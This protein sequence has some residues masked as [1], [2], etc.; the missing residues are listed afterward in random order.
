M[1]KVEL[2]A[3][4]RNFAKKVIK[5][6]L[7]DVEPNDYYT[8]LISRFILLKEKLIKKDINNKTLYFDVTE[9]IEYVP[10][11]RFIA[12]YVKRK[13]TKYIENDLSIKIQNKFGSNIGEEEIWIINKLRDSFVHGKYDID[14]YMNIININN[15]HSDDL[16]NAYALECKVPIEVLEVLQY[17]AENP[18]EEYDDSDIEEFIAYTNKVR[19]DFN[20]FIK[21]DKSLAIF[22]FDRLKPISSYFKTMY[23]QETDDNKEEKYISDSGLYI[24][25]EIKKQEKNLMELLYIAYNPLLTNEEELYKIDK[26]L[27]ENGIVLEQISYFYYIV[28]KKDPNMNPYTYLNKLEKAIQDI[29]ALLG[30][31]I[32]TTSPYAIPAL[33]NYMQTY[34]SLNDLDFNQGETKQKLCYLKTNNLRFEYDSSNQEYLTRIES[35]KKEVKDFIDKM[36]KKIEAYRAHPSDNFLRDIENKVQDF[37][38]KILEKFGDKNSIIFNS[39]RNSVEHGNVNDV[40]D[41]IS[42][43]DKNDQQSYDDNFVCLANANDLFELIYGLDTGCAKE[44]YTYK[45]FL[46]ELETVFKF[47]EKDKNHKKLYLEFLRVIVQIKKIANYKIDDIHKLV[48]K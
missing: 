39:I 46:N 21:V 22:F 16:H 9:S 31:K 6:K 26:I 28:T 15:D 40:N 14:E 29:A 7:Y 38:Y 43:T 19:K 32:D 45:D 3:T 8:L 36:K 13:A 4:S 24:E 5:D 48:K 30:V 2:I 17:I 11:I 10:A 27:E 42:L 37:H 20:Y 23:K 41:S 18:K 12:G 47:D 1:E 35:I 33:Y 34:F 25:T 44:E